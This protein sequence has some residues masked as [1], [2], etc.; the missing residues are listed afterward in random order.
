VE[1]GG[2]GF[3][4]AKGVF[5]LDDKWNADQANQHLRVT[6]DEIE[7]VSGKLSLPCAEALLIEFE[8]DIREAFLRQ[9]LAGV[10]SNCEKYTR[11][12]RALS[13]EKE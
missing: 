3:T 9:D 4:R 2:C 7:T 6:L 1:I 5:S 13:A 10:M 11:R 12:V 8:H